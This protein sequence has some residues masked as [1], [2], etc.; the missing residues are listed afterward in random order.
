MV[1]HEHHA[2]FAAHLDG[3]VQMMELIF[4]DEIAH[5]AGGDEEFVGEHAAGAVGG[6]QQVLGNDALQGI[7]QLHDDLFSAEP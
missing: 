5:G 1:V 7:G 4:P 2:V 6:G 3:V